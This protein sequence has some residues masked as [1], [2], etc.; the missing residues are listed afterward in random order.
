MT[1]SAIEPDTAIMPLSGFT[2]G[3]TAARRREELAAMLERRGARVVL[4]P[5]I[6]IVPV[7]DDGELLAATRACLA[8]PLDF[9]V[10]TTGIGFRGWLEAADGWGV[11]DALRQRLAA[12]RIF[13]RGPKA[14][15]AVRAAELVDEWSP[16]SESSQAV[17]DRLL[18]EDLAGKRI[19]VQLHGE[20]QLR[21]ASALRAAGAEVVE[22]PV[23]RWVMAEDRAPL[24]RL[25]EMTIARQVDA[26]AFTSAPAVA[27]T[28]RYSRG[29]GLDDAL[30][31]ALRSDV[32]AIC[33]G[34]VCAAPFSAAGVSA[35]FPERARLGALVRTVAEELPARRTR[36]ITVRGHLLEMRGQAVIY[37]GRLVPL[38]PG[39]LSLLRALAVRPGQV[40]SRTEL[41]GAL[42]GEGDE[43]AVEMTVARL[44]SALGDSGAVLTVVKR[45]YRLAAELGGNR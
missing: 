14:R 8:A 30:I 4:G 22:A 2:V 35:V 17:L 34:P 38:A 12:A 43:H 21:F 45:G 13:A 3:V 44:R 7:Q 32:L 16:E 40:L 31:D 42:G 29:E 39:P 24:R 37:A 33:V 36:R 18:G 10:A 6:R 28:L 1:E 25:I 19:A 9:V 20:P 26:L 11:A 23:Y 15:G 5:A 41:L 27:S